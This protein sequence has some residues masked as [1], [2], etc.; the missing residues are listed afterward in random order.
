[1]GGPPHGLAPADLPRTCS[2]RRPASDDLARKQA[3]TRARAQAK[4]KE[5][6][7]KAASDPNKTR[8]NK[9]VRGILVPE[10]AAS[11]AR[12][13]RA[14]TWRKRAGDTREGDGS[15]AAAAESIT[16][17]REMPRR[18]VIVTT[19]KRAEATQQVRNAKRDALPSGG[20]TSEARPSPSRSTTPPASRPEQ[21]FLQRPVEKAT[22]SRS[23]K[24]ALQ[25]V[26]TGEIEAPLRTSLSLVPPPPMA[27]GVSVH[28]HRISSSSTP[29]SAG[30]NVRGRRRHEVMHHASSVAPGSLPLSLQE[31]CEL[32]LIYA[33]YRQSAQTAK[34]KLLDMVQNPI[35]NFGNWEIVSDKSG[36]FDKD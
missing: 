31:W 29:T 28:V 12:K 30:D 25:A 17:P 7:R 27:R 8:K 32:A 18:S 33:R 5:R 2:D 10:A 9:R 14:K 16:Q 3:E 6:A 1:V 34:W 24:S 26:A 11:A 21:D 23:F 15:E 19:L 20:T 36:K 22:F 35:Y 4:V 13:R